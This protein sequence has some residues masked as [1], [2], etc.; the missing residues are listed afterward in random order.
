MSFGVAIFVEYQ[1]LF[2]KISFSFWRVIQNL[3]QFYIRNWNCMQLFSFKNWDLGLDPWWEILKLELWVF[4]SK[5]ETVDK[6]TLKRLIK[7]TFFWST[8]LICSSAILERRR[9]AYQLQFNFDLDRVLTNK[10]S[11]NKLLFNPIHGNKIHKL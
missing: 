6:K 7:S 10:I 3:F 5:E 9:L 2:V 4:L 1:L 8:F 11:T